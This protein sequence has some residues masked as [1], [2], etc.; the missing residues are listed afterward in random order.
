M[1]LPWKTMRTNQKPWN[2]LEKPPAVP[3]R[4]LGGQNCHT[5]GPSNLLGGRYAWIGRDFTSLGYSSSQPQERHRLPRCSA[6]ETSAWV[7]PVLAKKFN[8]YIKYLIL[9]N[10]VNSQCS[11][12]QCVLCSVRCPCIFYDPVSD[13]IR[14]RGGYRGIFKEE[15]VDTGAYFRGNHGSRV[16]KSQKCEK[17]YI[18]HTR[19]SWK[20]I[21]NKVHIVHCY[22]A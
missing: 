7:P 12:A 22:A 17:V 6:R 18:P 5:R 2:K 16:W 8:K 13:T 4:S 14:R 3:P 21:L 15:G 19:T 9:A 10:I 1:K 11:T 20:N